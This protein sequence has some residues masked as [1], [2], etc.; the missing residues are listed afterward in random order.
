[1]ASIQE[2]RAGLHRPLRRSHPGQLR[3]VRAELRWPRP[4][5]HPRQ[6]RPGSTQLSAGGSQL[7]CQRSRQIN[8]NNNQILFY[9]QRF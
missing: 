4:R 7:H 2:R 8:M 5:P 3:P 9:T 1:M 6:L